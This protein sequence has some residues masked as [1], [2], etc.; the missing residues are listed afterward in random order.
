MIIRKNKGR[1]IEN[2]LAIFLLTKHDSPQGGLISNPMYTAVKH[3]P[4]YTP[5]KHVPMYT[6]NKRAPPH[7]SPKSDPTWPEWSRIKPRSRNQNPT[8]HWKE[9]LGLMANHIGVYTGT[10]RT[11]GVHWERTWGVYWERTWGV[12][13][14]FPL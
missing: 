14:D 9:S 5:S 7:S 8:F 11:W 13:W 1:P 10:E 3:D 4:S 12:H 6:P 2:A